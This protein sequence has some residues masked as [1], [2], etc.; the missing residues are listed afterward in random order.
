MPAEQI[1][2]AFTPPNREGLVEFL[3]KEMNFNE[4]RVKKVVDKLFKARS[5]GAQMRLVR[6]NHERTQN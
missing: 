5:T 1:E 4:D 3:V 6:A 2:F